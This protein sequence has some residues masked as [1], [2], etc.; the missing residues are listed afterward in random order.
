M[1]EQAH[2]RRGRGHERRCDDKENSMFRSNNDNHPVFAPQPHEEDPVLEEW[3]KS[4]HRKLV[5]SIS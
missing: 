2:R 3:N 5:V 4:L 1:R